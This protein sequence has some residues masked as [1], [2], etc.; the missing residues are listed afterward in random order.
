MSDTSYP[1]NAIVD[2]RVIFLKDVVPITNADGELTI[3]RLS[4]NLYFNPNL[5]FP[6]Q[7]IAAPFLI[8]MTEINETNSPGRWLFLFNTNGYPK[9]TYIPVATDANFEADNVPLAGEAI[10]GEGLA[11]ATEF[12]A[13]GAV[14]K[15]EYN[16]TTSETKLSNWQDP[17]TVVKTFDNQ[18]ENGDP[19]GTSE[20][21]KKIPQ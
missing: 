15:A 12:A 4:D 17:N 20:P 9:D 21:S 11:E 3:Q 6:N 7:W 19:A 14:G 5:V 13:A 8:D 16:S 1:L 2:I 10:V 18:L